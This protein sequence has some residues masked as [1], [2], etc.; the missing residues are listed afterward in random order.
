MQT[1]FGAPA[2]LCA[3][4]H[5]RSLSPH[6]LEQIHDKNPLLLLVQGV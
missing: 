1:L 3:N 2:A 4:W 6:F 5:D